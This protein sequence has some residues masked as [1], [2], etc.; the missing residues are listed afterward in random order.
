MLLAIVFGVL[1]RSF[2][3]EH[4]YTPVNDHV[5]VLVKT[6]YMNALK[7]IVAPV[8]FFSIISCIGQFSNLSEIGKI[9]GRTILLYCFTTVIAALLGTAMFYLFRPGEFGS[10][11]FDTAAATAEAQT[12]HVS[13]TDM[14]VNIVPDNFFKPF[15]EAEMLQLIFLAVLCGIAVGMIGKYS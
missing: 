1:L 2:V 5:L 7:M 13:F 8:V 14:I 3:P 11:I 4:I 6:M 12:V 9:G 15:L 10:V